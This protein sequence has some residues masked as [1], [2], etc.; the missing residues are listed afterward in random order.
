MT[1]RR[2]KKV[3]FPFRFFCSQ[4]NRTKRN[5]RNEDE[6]WALDVTLHGVL[7]CAA[8]DASAA[9]CTDHVSSDSS[10][11]IIVSRTFID[12]LSCLKETNRFLFANNNGV[13]APPIVLLSWA[14]WFRVW[15]NVKL[16]LACLQSANWFQ[17]FLSWS[18]PTFS[19]GRHDFHLMP[20]SFAFKFAFVQE[21]TLKGNND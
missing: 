14:G 11:W 18:C 13:D 17:C 9:I 7:G 10:I 12:R 5:N 4:Q 3:F 19:C 6:K 8:V 20:T 1:C 16:I 15:S 21:K 2:R